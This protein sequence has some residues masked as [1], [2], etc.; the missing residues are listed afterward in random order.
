MIL[1]YCGLSVHCTERT[2]WQKNADSIYNLRILFT[3]CG[4]RLQFADS[5]YTCGFRNSSFKLYT[6]PIICLWISETGPDSANTVVDSANSPSF[7]RILSETLFSVIAGGI[8]NI[9]EGHR[10]LADHSRE[11]HNN[12]A[13]SSTKMI[14]ACCGLSLQCTE[15]TVWQTKCWFRSQFAGYFNL[16][17]HLF[18]SANS[19]MDSANLPSFV[20]ILTATLFLVFVCGIQ[21]SKEDHRKTL[22]SSKEDH[23]NVAEAATNLIVACC[24]I[25]LQFTQCT[26]WPRNVGILCLWSV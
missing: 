20:A 21:N 4:F 13:D 25:R 3:I 10:K 1:A 7:G 2:I 18:Y 11:N 15:R 5:T 16:A 9:K 12:V 6:S 19:I 24:G 26:V 23:S 22:R 14:L 17:I 8:Q